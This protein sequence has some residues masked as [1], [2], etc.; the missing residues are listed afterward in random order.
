MWAASQ[1]D[2]LKER[3]RKTETG[4][5]TERRRER[6]RERERELAKTQLGDRADIL[7]GQP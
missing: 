6:E 7:R 3:E 2:L 5:E 4:R 1:A